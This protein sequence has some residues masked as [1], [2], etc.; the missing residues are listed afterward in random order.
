M[1]SLGNDFKLLNAENVTEGLEIRTSGTLLFQSD[2]GVMVTVCDDYFDTDVGALICRLMGYA[3][4]DSYRQSRDSARYDYSIGMDDLDCPSDATS[5]W[6]DCSFTT[7]HNCGHDEDLSIT[8][9]NY[10]NWTTTTTSDYYILPR[11]ILV[12]VSGKITVPQKNHIPFTRVTLLA[13]Y[14]V[15]DGQSRP[16]THIM[17]KLY[18]LYV[19]YRGT[20][21]PPSISIWDILVNILI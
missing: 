21:A 15:V 20:L 16:T 14:S 6:D 12:K 13:R 2:T 18:I 3:G 8:C 5:L 11:V 10:G 1:L 9:M 19:L 7:N 17:Y 4:Y